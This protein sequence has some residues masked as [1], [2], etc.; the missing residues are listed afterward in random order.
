MNEEEEIKKAWEEI[1][2]CEKEQSEK[3]KSVLKIASWLL[4]YDEFEDLKELIH[5]SDTTSYYSI[6][7]KPKGEYQVDSDYN[8]LKGYWVNQTINGGYVGD[9]YAGTISVKLLNDKYFQFHYSM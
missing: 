6:E 9:E 4:T 2:L 5:D 3:D 8:F 7:A 1:E